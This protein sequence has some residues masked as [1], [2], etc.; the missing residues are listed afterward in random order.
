MIKL[1][2]FFLLIYYVVLKN[3]KLIFRNVSTLSVL[4]IG[5]LLL[6]LIVGFAF[7][8]EDLHGISVGIIS[9]DNAPVE[10]VVQRFSTPDIHTT[11][12]PQLSLCL[13]DL[14]AEKIHICMEFSEDFQLTTLGNNTITLYTDPTRFVLSRQLL[15]YMQ[16]HLM[17]ASEQ[18]SLEAARGI[19]T[20]IDS[21]VVTLNDIQARVR[22]FIN[23]TTE[24]QQELDTLD[25]TL[26]S[27]QKKVEA[28]NEQITAT[29]A[30]LKKNVNVLNLT[31]TTLAS[32]LSNLSERLTSLEK[33]AAR[34]STQTTQL[35]EWLADYNDRV[36]SLIIV[37]KNYS[38][39][40]V[41][42]K[43]I[44]LLKLNDTSFAQINTTVL[45]QT[46]ESLLTIH[47][48]LDLL[49]QNTD[50]IMLF[51]NQ[52]QTQ[53]GNLEALAT[54]WNTTHERL[55]LHRQKLNRTTQ[56]LIVLN[57]QLDYFIARLSH[58]DK[59]QAEKLLHPII[60]EEN[61]L[62]KNLKKIN[63]IFPVLLVFVISFISILLAN[64]LVSN[65][66]HSQAYFRNF[67]A[68]VPSFI[69]HAGLFITTFLLVCFQTTVLVAV[70]YLK[71]KITLLHVLP[72]VSLVAIISTMIFIQIGMALAYTIRVRHNSILVSTFVTLGIFLF[73][74]V[75][76]PLE[77]MPQ[78]AA[79]LAQW[80]PLVVGEQL[81]RMSIFYGI[82][83]QDNL[84]HLLI[85]G[86]ALVSVTIVTWVAHYVHK[87]RPSL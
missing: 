6:I 68:P 51:V 77:T 28:H 73:S 49:Q 40:P 14:K 84:S 64:I 63:L 43:G 25:A 35:M 62:L 44:S 52:T 74:D 21:T 33:D 57:H 20:D 69:F 42:I 83:L 9:S 8:G 11:N 82:S 87:N 53:L 7:G 75:I 72:A 22:E 55:Q 37:A 12:Y 41:L 59:H 29:Q 45:N 78:F 47:I 76:F 85:F 3:L 60:I 17:N 81:F 46:Q 32:T 1:L 38:V 61:S 71:F 70:A 5:P 2:R 15:H 23:Y 66:I 48:S 65:E 26:Q 67:L 79:Y 86:A 56:E 27:A 4:I 58:I 24:L 31:Q 54:L 18:V 30:Q 16:Q 36:D 13:F 19:L 39:S 50:T 10:S 34:L 80:N